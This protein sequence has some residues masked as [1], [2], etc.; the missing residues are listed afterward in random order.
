METVH[1]EPRRLRHAFVV[2]II[3]AA[4]VVCT[5]FF[6]DH[7]SASPAS[8]TQPDLSPVGMPSTP[9]SDL[10]LPSMCTL[11]CTFEEMQSQATPSP[12]SSSP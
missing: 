5:L 1:Y 7:G 12:G 2:A 4:I 6:A 11:V 3:V 9:A 8:R 10:T